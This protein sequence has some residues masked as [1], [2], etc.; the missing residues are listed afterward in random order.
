MS[1]DHMYLAYDVP[2]VSFIV[3]LLLK[4][5]QSSVYNFDGVI[6]VLYI[7]AISFIKVKTV[8]LYP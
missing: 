7:L 6:K 1:C 2:C 4:N 3:A 5:E 8:M